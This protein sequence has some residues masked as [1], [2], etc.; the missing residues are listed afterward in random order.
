MAETLYQCRHCEKWVSPAFGADAPAEHQ[1]A[2]GTQEDPR[3]P[4]DHNNCCDHCCYGSELC[5]QRPRSPRKEPIHAQ[6]YF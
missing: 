6:Y 4:G 3:S 2:E 5:K 1:G